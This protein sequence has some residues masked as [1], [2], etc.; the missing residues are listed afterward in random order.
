MSG[1]SGEG[2]SGYDSTVARARAQGG[3]RES[4]GSEGRMK[5]LRG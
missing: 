2:S 4:G 1:G 3:E 5:L